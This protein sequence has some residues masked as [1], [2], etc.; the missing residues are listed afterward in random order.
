MGRNLPEQLFK[1]QI[2]LYLQDFSNKISIVTSAI[3]IWSKKYVS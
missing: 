2:S 3:E 1:G